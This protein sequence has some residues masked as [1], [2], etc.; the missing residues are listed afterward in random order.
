M[1]LIFACGAEC[2]IAATG[3]A[4]PA[5]EHWSAK[6]G[7]VTV[8]AAPA[9]FLSEN[10][11]RFQSAGS[12][13][14]VTHT[15]ATAIASPATMVVRCR[16]MF[17]GSLPSA[18][19][20]L[21]TANSTSSS[22]YFNFGDSTLR[23][24]GAGG[25][26]V[27]GP[28]VVPDQVYVVELSTTRNTTSNCKLV[29]DGVDYGSGNGASTAIAFT[30]CIVGI[31]TTGV[32][33]D[34]YIDDVA[35]SG[36]AAD[37]PLGN[38]TIVGLYPDSDGTHAFNAAG[39]FGKGAGGATNLTV[40]SETTSWQSLANPL[41]TSVQTNWL[42]ARAA[43]L[44]GSEF[45][46]H[47]YEALPSNAG[48][49]NTVAVV[50]THHAE[51]TTA[52]AASLSLN[53]GGTLIVAHAAIDFSAV[54]IQVAYF[55]RATSAAGTAWTVAKVN[56]LLTRWWG[57]DVT[58]DDYLDGV[59]LEVDY[60]PHADAGHA[61]AT[62]AA[63]DATISA[64]SNSDTA[65]A[66]HAAATGTANNAS[67]AVK[68]TAGN[69]A[70]TGA[71]NNASAAVKPSAGTTAATGVAN[72]ATTLVR[73]T[74]GHAAA[75]AAAFDATVSTGG[76]SDTAPAGNAAATASAFN[77]T[78]RV[79]ASAGHASATGVARAPAA[80][81]RPN[82]GHAAATGVA[83]A[84]SGAVKPSAG[85]AA[86][87]GLAR[88]PSEAVAPR[89]G[90]AAATGVARD[91]TIST[92]SSDTAPAGN[93]AA[94]GTA[95]NAS[96][97]V[98]AS[99]GHASASAAVNTNMAAIRPRAGHASATGAAFTASVLTGARAIA[100]LASASAVAHDVR[101]SIHVMAALAAATG[102]AY[103]A[104]GQSGT[105][106]LHPITLTVHEHGH[107]ATVTER[108]NTSTAFD[109]DGSVTLT[110]QH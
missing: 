104:D 44:D 12:A 3:T 101:V 54:S 28:V 100:G 61:S 11:F 13:S 39:D 25:A 6:T 50:S 106:D 84:V 88:T 45:L 103:D 93:A 43:A 73:P 81:V 60:K 95:F 99:A 29:V 80:A 21:V 63:F 89:A 4:H 107:T 78:I 27:V 59:C 37:Y 47:G 85:H 97:R 71:A 70:A 96:V 82:A 109:R 14:T 9:G 62:G 83:R 87:T 24:N 48:S 2:N 92:L 102:T 35:I 1:A 72:N 94:T 69:A 76:V 42:S 19:T 110:E 53:D 41:S 30:T 79:G 7:T 31:G 57:T 15:F 52:N 38:G 86:A 65:P 56:A 67:A 10:V 68:P 66:E 20:N 49:V 33:G 75:T 77:A 36:T 58:P 51:S 32:T 8:E 16:V 23:A 5:I 64:A 34:V 26:G 18:D 74:A 55:N 91:A 17:N 90:N 98:Q 108:G 105:D 46:Q 40:G 22:F